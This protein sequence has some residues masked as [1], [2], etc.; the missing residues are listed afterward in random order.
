MPDTTRTVTER[1][2]TP[3]A[4]A[5]WLHAQGQEPS[6]HVLAWFK[7]KGVAWPPGCAAGNGATPAAA[8]A[9]LH[10]DDV[11]DPETLV[12]YRQQF[13]G[14]DH[15][16][17][18]PWTS[19]H[20]AFLGEAVRMGGGAA[21]LAKLL[22]VTAEAEYRQLRTAKAEAAEKKRADAFTSGLRQRAP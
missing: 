22:G 17:R 15:Q 13:K 16:K 8:P 5:A 14:V 20:R 11:K 4:F 7:H 10:A 2:V 9:V 12:S 6:V 18:P 21:E 19:E 1:R 3:A